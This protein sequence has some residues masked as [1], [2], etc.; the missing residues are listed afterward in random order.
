MKTV[1]KDRVEG[2]TDVVVVEYA[3]RAITFLLERQN[4]QA[5]IKG[6]NPSSGLHTVYSSFNQVMKLKTGCDW[7]EVTEVLLK[8][9]FGYRPAKGGYRVYLPEDWK[10][11]RE[12]SVGRKVESLISE[13]G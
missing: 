4:K 6:Y 1:V 8:A 3:R 2:K 9:G 10:E 7:K 11:A 12:M 5:E 13:I